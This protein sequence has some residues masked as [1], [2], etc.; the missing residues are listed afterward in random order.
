MSIEDVGLHPSRGARTD[1]PLGPGPKELLETDGGAGA[2]NP[3]RHDADLN[4][5]M[6]TGERNVFA[7]ATQFLHVLEVS[8]RVLCSV[9]ISHHQHP[10]GKVTSSKSQNGQTGILGNPGFGH[11]LR[12]LMSRSRSSS[13]VHHPIEARTSPVFGIS[14]TITPSSSRW[15]TTFAGSALRQETMVAR[16]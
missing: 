2:T 11:N 14:R 10:A 15:A 7:G 5:V 3:V 1:D 16:S 4:V 8:C 13:L 12:P 6:T 9:G